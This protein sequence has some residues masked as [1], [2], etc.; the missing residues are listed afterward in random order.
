MTPAPTPEVRTAQAAERPCQL[1]THRC[2]PRPTRTQGHHRKPVYLQNRVYGRIV[3]NELMWLC[4]LDHDSTHDWIAW[5]LGEAR[6]PNPEPGYKA[7]A[8]ARR[9]VAWYLAALDE[10]NRS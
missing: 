8:E 3:D 2:A 4:G 10:R 9:T 6:K 1:Y 5:L 7:K